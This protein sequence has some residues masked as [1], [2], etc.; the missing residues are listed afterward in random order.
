MLKWALQRP[1]DNHGAAPAEASALGFRHPLARE[2]QAAIR[3]PHRGFNDATSPTC[4]QRRAHLWRSLQ[5]AAASCKRDLLR[6]S[7]RFFQLDATSCVDP[8]CGP[9]GLTMSKAT[10]ELCRD[11]SPQP[12]RRFPVVPEPRPQKTRTGISGRLEPA[13]CLEKPLGQMDVV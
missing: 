10:Q 4:M 9:P 13:D 6:F 8:A 2:V 12:L 11:F 5:G 3:A 7:T 1:Y